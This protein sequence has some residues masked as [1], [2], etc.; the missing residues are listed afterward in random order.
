MAGALFL[1]FGVFLLLLMSGKRDIMTADVKLSVFQIRFPRR[2]NIYFLSNNV[3]TEF[4][5]YSEVQ[6]KTSLGMCFNHCCKRDKSA[7]ICAGNQLF[8]CSK[9]LAFKNRMKVYISW[10]RPSFIITWRGTWKVRKIL[11]FLMTLQAHLKSHTERMQ[12]A[13]CDFGSPP[14]CGVNM[15]YLDIPKFK[16]GNENSTKISDNFEL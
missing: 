15:L 10:N 6:W 3:V 5:C 8:N 14:D 12:I 9:V 13:V 4:Q 16:F 1:S 11:H 2:Y 7:F